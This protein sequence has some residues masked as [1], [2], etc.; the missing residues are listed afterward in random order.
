MI[1]ADLVTRRIGT[2]SIQRLTQFRSD[3]KFVIGSA[4]ES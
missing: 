3:A 1:K 2:I 4:R